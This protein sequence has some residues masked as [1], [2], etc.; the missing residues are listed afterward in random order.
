MMRACDLQMWRH[1]SAFV[2]FY[3]SLLI[4]RKTTD[5]V[6]L[7]MVYNTQQDYNVMAGSWWCRPHGRTGHSTVSLKQTSTKMLPPSYYRHDNIHFCLLC[8][9]QHYDEVVCKGKSPETGCCRLFAQ[10]W[11]GF[12]V[13]CCGRFHSTLRRV[14]FD[15]VQCREVFRRLVF[16]FVLVLQRGMMGVWPRCCCWEWIWMSREK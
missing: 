13:G 5:S 9:L 10:H 7:Q 14:F 1:C 12:S 2:C 3:F 11:R 8:F 4:D 15:P 16:L 6:F